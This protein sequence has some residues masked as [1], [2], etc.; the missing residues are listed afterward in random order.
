MSK[1]LKRYIQY[2][3]TIENLLNRIYQGTAKVD[4]LA[5]LIMHADDQELNLLEYQ[6][7]EYIK[8][9]FR[10]EHYKFLSKLQTI[11]L[12]DIINKI[13]DDLFSRI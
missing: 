6:V 2:N 1:M 8:K 3:I 11:Q 9:A 5:F 4:D 13:Q 10:E 12:D 7:E